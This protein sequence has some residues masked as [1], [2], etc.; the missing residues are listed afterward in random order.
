[1]FG[2]LSLVPA[3]TNFRIVGNQEV[4]GAAP[5]PHRGGVTGKPVV[6]QTIATQHQ[7]AAVGEHNAIAKRVAVEDTFGQLPR[8]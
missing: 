2:R 3:N 4:T 6:R 1:M 8:T 5:P 7:T